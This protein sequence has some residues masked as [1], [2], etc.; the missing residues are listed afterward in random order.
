MQSSDVQIQLDWSHPPSQS[1]SPPATQDGPREA[2]EEITSFQKQQLQQHSLNRSPRVYAIVPSSPQGHTKDKSPFRHQS[3]DQTP[4]KAAVSTGVL[5]T[6]H[7]YS[8]QKEKSKGFLEDGRFE[9]EAALTA[10]HESVLFEANENNVVPEAHLC[11]KRIFVQ[12]GRLKVTERSGPYADQLEE[13]LTLCLCH[14][15][16]ENPQAVTCQ[17]FLEYTRQQYNA[18]LDQK[19]NEQQTSLVP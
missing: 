13:K 2:E 12:I 18:Y 11:A 9:H 5:I 16:W 19:Q 4:T 14:R 10:G 15:T 17:E 1:R 3:L 6:G 7:T 8:Q